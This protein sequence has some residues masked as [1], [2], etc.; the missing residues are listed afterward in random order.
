MNFVNNTKI[1]KYNFKKV[2]P[3]I[4]YSVENV[5]K[6]IFKS[7]QDSFT[8]KTNTHFRV[9][10]KWALVLLKYRESWNVEKYVVEKDRIKFCQ[11]CF[12]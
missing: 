9:W 10:S 8:Q 2:F 5:D 12:F 4:S 7:Y 11:V 1:I 6:W 3:G